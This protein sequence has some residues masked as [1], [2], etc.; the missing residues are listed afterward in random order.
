MNFTERAGAEAEVPIIWPPDAKSW[1]IRRDL[2]SGKYWRQEVKGMT[3][4]KMIGWPHRLD[5][6]EF[7]QALGDG[8]GQ[9]GLACCSPWGHKESDTTEWLSNKNKGFLGGSVVKNL[10]ANV[11][12]LDSIPQV[13]KIPSNRKWQPPQYSCLGES[14]GQRSLAGYSPGCCKNQTRLSGQEHAVFC[15]FKMTELEF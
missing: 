3:E 13:R 2:D 8:E 9:G 4:D 15:C 7:E 5:G 6:H 12:N 10:L 14:H 1:L 11:R